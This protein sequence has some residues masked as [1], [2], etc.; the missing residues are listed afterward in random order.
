[1]SGHQTVLPRTGPGLH[2]RMA[3]HRSPNAT[4]FPSTLQ[5]PSVRL[6]PTK[7]GKTVTIRWSHP[8]KTHHPPPSPSAVC[9]M[10]QIK[11][12]KNL[13]V[14]GTRCPRHTGQKGRHVPLALGQTNVPC[15]YYLW[16][17]LDILRTAVDMKQLIKHTKQAKLCHQ[18]QTLITDATRRGP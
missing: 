18:G 12:L 9:F 5:T 16:A 2:P 1:M 8:R 3:Q 14:L 11:R 17:A 13:A 15:L 4:R 7:E 10:T 6:A